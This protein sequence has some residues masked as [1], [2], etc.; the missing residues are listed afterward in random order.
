MTLEEYVKSL[1]RERIDQIKTD[2]GAA[3]K[4]EEEYNQLWG[5]QKEGDNGLYTTVEAPV[6]NSFDLTDE[7]AT[8]KFIGDVKKTDGVL[9]ERIKSGQAGAWEEALKKDS[10][11]FDRFQKQGISNLSDEDYDYF[12][13]AQTRGLLE[14]DESLATSFGRGLWNMAKGAGSLIATLGSSQTSPAAALEGLATIVEGAQQGVSDY[15]MLGAGSVLLGEKMFGD[16][17]EVEMAA[18][19]ELARYAQDERAR[20]GE[21]RRAIGG[22][23]LA[24]VAVDDNAVEVMSEVM[25]V[26]NLIGAGLG[27]KV[28]TKGMSV[29]LIDEAVAKTLTR[30]YAAD[31]AFKKYFFPKTLGRIAEKVSGPSLTALEG[32]ARV[33]SESSIAARE[34]LSAAEAKVSSARMTMAQLPEGERAAFLKDT[35]AP[36]ETAVETARKDFLA[37]ASQLDANRKAVTA[38]LDEAGTSMA[39]RAVGGAIRVAGRGVEKTGEALTGLWNWTKRTV[40]DGEDVG[41]VVDGA[42]DAATGGATA[43]ARQGNLVTRVG[44]DIKVVGELY[45][46][47]ETTLAFSRRLRQ[48]QKASRLTRAGAAFVDGSGIGWTLGKGTEFARA[49]AAGAP[50]SG[51]FGFVA[52]GGDMNAA[53]ESAGSGASFGIGGGV[54]GQWEAYTDPKVRYEEL[55]GNRRNFRQWLM[56]SGDRNGQLQMFDQLPATEQILMGTYAHAHPDAAF[57]FTREGRNGPAGFYDRDRNVITINAD[58]PDP[59]SRTFTHEIAHFIERHGLANQVRDAY[60]GNAETGQIGQYTK[61]VDGKPVVV[62]TAGPDGTTLRSYELNDEGLALKRDYEGRVQKFKPDFTM[63]DERF[64]SELFAEQYSDRLRSGRFLSDLKAGSPVDA[65]ANSSLVKG[66][67]AKLG[68]LFDQNDKVIGTGLFDGLRRNRTVENL[69]REYNIQTSKGQRNTIEEDADVELTAEDL[70]NSDLAIKWLQAGGAVKFGPD[71]LPVM[72]GGKVQFMTDGEAD[73]VQ[74]D[75][76]NDLITAIDKWVASNPANADAVQRREITDING[77]KRVTYSGA[78]LP[79]EIID[80]IEATQKYNPHQLAT[81]RATSK[82]IEKNGPGSILAHFYQ[83]AQ[84]KNRTGKYASVRG[85]WRRDAAYGFQVSQQ[86]NVLIQSFSWEQLFANAKKAA[87]TK[88]ARELWG[89]TGEALDAAIAGDVVTYLQNLVANKPGAESLGTAKRD[90]VNNLLGFRTKANEGVNPLFDLTQQPK[91]II[92]SLRIDRMNRM[93]PLDVVEYAW[94]P[95]QYR[96]AMANLSPG[97][98]QATTADA[99]LPN[100]LD[101]DIQ[102]SPGGPEPKKTVKAYKLFRTMKSKPG[103]LFPLFIGNDKPV[104]VGQWLVAENLPTKGFAARPGWHA[105]STPNAPH[106]M[107][108]DGMSMQPGRVWAEVSMPADVDYTPEAQK[109]P[110]RDIKDRVPEG[111][112]YKFSTQ[113]QQGEHGWIIGGALKVERILKPEEVDAVNAKFGISTKTEYT[114]VNVQYSTGSGNTSTDSTNT[115]PNDS[116]A[117][118]EGS[119]TVSTRR[120]YRVSPADA[121]QR[122]HG[123]IARAASEHRKGA[124]VEV[125]PA[126]FYAD[127]A[128]EY[129]LAEDDSAG[130]AVKPDGNLVS[131]FKHPASK[132]RMGDLLTEASQKATKLDGF[133]IDGFLPTYYSKF[134]FRPVARVAFA[135]EFAPAGWNFDENG[136]PD[137]VFMVRDP[138]NKLGLPNAT[139]YNAV[140]EQVPLLSYDEAVKMQADT[141]AKLSAP[142]KAKPIK[143][144]SYTK[145]ATITNDAGV[146]LENLSI[147][148]AKS[149]ATKVVLDTQPQVLFSRLDLAKEKLIDDPMRLADHKGYV[150]FMRDAGVYGDVL[151]APP[152]LRVLLENPQAYVDNLLGGYHGELTKPGTMEAADAGLDATVRMRQAINGRPPELVTALHHFW[153]ILSRMLPPV[154]QESAWLRLVSRPQIIEQIQNS[155]DGNFALTQDQW[156]A[157]VQSSLRETN[158]VAKGRGNQ[159]TANANAFYAMLARWNGNWSK[160]SDVY[161]AD[162]SIDSGRAFWSLGLGPIGI[163][164]KVQRFIGL[165]FGIPGLIMDRWKF[166]EFYYPQFGQKA[167]EYFNYSKTGTPEDP[168]GIYGAY[169]LIEGSNSAFSLAFYEGM[170]TVLQQAIDRSP[171]LQKVLGRH[172]NVGGLHWKGWNAIKNEAVGHSSLDL[173]YDL[174]TAD[175]TAK[176]ETLLRLFGEKE[177]YTEGLAGNTLTRFTLPKSR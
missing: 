148:K 175:P 168:N 52:S 80:E 71:G 107:K 69:I 78:Y 121:G 57:V 141:V 44:R 117:P 33:L 88:L 111:G 125:K 55:L 155:I 60:L 105:G 15:K 120:G 109:Q 23:G 104:P 123:A 96:Q 118:S 124:A 151:T 27:K 174:L 16:N 143:L 166:V 140:R 165:T 135:D 93:A 22:D 89:T 20:Q 170:E 34:A 32:Q 86:G 98:E 129:F 85:R 164:N 61:L 97:S 19:F 14:N 119:Q 82:M 137:N 29:G 67:L 45:R 74:R 136:R 128:N 153:G 13:W 162:N 110:T 76:A 130:A 54:L 84:R 37:V 114:D 64:A 12:K 100:E 101:D 79:A 122:F 90:F 177:Y 65:F 53:A 169:G 2:L 126:E 35:V 160:V 91:T 115:T 18:R 139:D 56:D 146:Q 26:S 158:D 10:T 145:R 46:Q 11:N 40:T 102:F 167:S 63:S 39:D 38:S 4:V 99:A 173:T 116:Q 171:E 81:L 17:P 3:S 73:A 25:D 68:F 58:H 113:K 134:G 49:A 24:A 142:K 176:P 133:D 9:F 75:L 31:A 77:K 92:T 157:L 87:N 163:K 43:V 112:F 127:P 70:K 106:L 94:G 156:K 50:V 83:A 8:T 147:E 138:E 51:A 28:V 47:G 150:E 132:V 159:G 21:W 5:D 6:A 36:L 172:A 149:S 154:E 66:T 41:G 48:S 103:Q 42:I 59:V 144:P 108:K 72:S 7:A 131:V 62:E 95:Q 161:A 1:P 152:T 30:E